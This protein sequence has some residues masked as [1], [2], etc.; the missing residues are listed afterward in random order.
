MQRGRSEDETAWAE[1]GP[2]PGPVFRI[3]RCTNNKMPTAEHRIKCTIWETCTNDKWWKGNDY[4]WRHDDH[5]I[6]GT[7]GKGSISKIS[8]WECKRDMGGRIYR[9]SS[10]LILLSH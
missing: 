9:K 7:D 10:A 5:K 6:L 8:S 3:G 2:V 1:W 4:G